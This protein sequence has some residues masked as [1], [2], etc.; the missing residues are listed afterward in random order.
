M[1]GLGSES[2]GW[3]GRFRVARFGV[4][5]LWVGGFGIG[6]FCVW[7]GLGLKSFDWDGLGLDMYLFPKQSLLYGVLAV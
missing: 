1:E 5:E 3:E 6:E 2:F 4:G 7:E